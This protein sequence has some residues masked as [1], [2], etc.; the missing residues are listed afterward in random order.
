VQL[1]LVLTRKTLKVFTLTR[2]SVVLTSIRS[3]T[4]RPHEAWV[5]TV[6]RVDRLM[7]LSTSA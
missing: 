7:L 5:L 2:S 1:R 4:D 3:G 6:I